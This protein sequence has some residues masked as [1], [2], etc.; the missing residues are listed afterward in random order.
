MGHSVDGQLA[1]PSPAMSRGVLALLT[2]IALIVAFS[3]SM[4]VPAF[5]IIAH[6]YG[7]TP[8]EVAW[9]SAIYLLIGAASVPLVGKLADIYGRKRLL[10]AVMAIYSAA[11]LLNAFTWNLESLI[12]SRAIQGVGLAM[13]PLAFALIHD[14]VARDRV[15]LATGIVS[16]MNSIGS[17]IGLVG[18]AWITEQFGWHANYL[19][20]APA[21]IALTVALAVFAVE[22]PQR[23]RSGVDYVG[24]AFFA[25]GIGLVLTGLTEGA[26]LG[27]TSIGTVLL[28]GSGAA[29]IGLF[30]LQERRASA[31]LMD[32]KLP[33]IRN[34]L[35][36]DALMF[37][38]GAAF[39]L[40]FQLVTY[41]CQNPAPGFGLDVTD[42][43]LVMLPGAALMI[44]FALLAGVLMRRVGIRFPEFIALVL[45]VVGFL[46]FLF[47]HDT[48]TQIAVGFVPIVAGVAMLFNS[49]VNATMVLAPAEKVGTQ[50]GALT[51]FQEVGQSVAAAIVG[52]TLV[53]F[54]NPVTLVPTG[55]AYLV[56]CLIGI[57]FAALGFLVLA[58]LPR[59]TIPGTPA[60]LRPGPPTT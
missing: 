55:Q 51:V 48:V 59:I 23:E 46:S 44:V 60:A 37:I 45:F 27:W 43:A 26:V 33:G 54:L 3:E 52:A 41:F 24:A 40:G 11:A 4:L 56:L 32:F 14:E 34:M 13:F 10:V 58:T 42:A 19:I 2:G 25:I 30:V 18:G 5:P 22:S 8:N 16:G 6:Q 57:G 15:P 53:S 49:V 47:F 50:N 20:L 36:T 39:Y 28:F 29:M 31:P 9:V 1:V 12:V 17:T 7:S 21:S 35:K 38:A